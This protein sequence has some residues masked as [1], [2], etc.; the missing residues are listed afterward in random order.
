MSLDKII[1]EYYINAGK[2]IPNGRTGKRTDPNKADYVLKLG[3]DYKIAVI[4]AKA[5]NKTPR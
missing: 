3:H 4:E 2:I 5:W 1:R